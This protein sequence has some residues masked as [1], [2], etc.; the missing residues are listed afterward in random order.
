MKKVSFTENLA[1]NDQR[2]VT[3]VLMETPFSKEIRILLKKGQVMKEHQAP[4]PIIIHILQGEIDFG[5]QGNVK[6]LQQGDMITL[7]SAVPHDLLAKSDSIVRL[8]LSKADTAER[9]EKVV[10]NP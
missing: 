3:K 10:H 1:F 7:A 6:V 2:I 5:V 8:T 4:L 9:V